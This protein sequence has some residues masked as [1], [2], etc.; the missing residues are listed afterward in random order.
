M[1]D[2][3]ALQ[4]LEAADLNDALGPWA[5][6]TPTFASSGTQPTLGNSTLAGR[7]K[8]QFSTT[9]D[10]LIS[11]QIGSTF[12]PGTGTYRFGLPAGLIALAHR[13]AIGSAYV[14]DTSAVAHYAGVAILRSNGTEITVVLNT[15]ELAATAPITWATGDEIRLGVRTEIS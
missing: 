15:T 14:F 5:S 13:R 8:R 4:E 12:T 9:L 11:L 2:F 6:Y 10:V 1:A 7:Y 3:L